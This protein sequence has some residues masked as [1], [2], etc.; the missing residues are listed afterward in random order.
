MKT[1]SVLNGTFT[2][3]LSQV[4][5]LNSLS[6]SPI[7]SINEKENTFDVIDDKKLEKLYKLLKKEANND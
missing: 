3:T 6:D 7:F 1:S 4:R 5:L 2:L